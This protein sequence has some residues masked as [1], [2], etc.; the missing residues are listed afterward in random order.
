MIGKLKNGYFVDP[1]SG[2]AFKLNLIVMGDFGNN[3]DKI[4]AEVGRVGALCQHEAED[5]FPTLGFLQKTWEIAALN[6]AKTAEQIAS[7]TRCFIYL[8]K[9][10]ANPEETILPYGFEELGFVWNGSNNKVYT[11]HD[12]NALGYRFK[13]IQE[14]QIPES[15]TGETPTNGGTTTSV[16]FIHIQC[17]KCGYKIF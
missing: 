15:P 17:P 5:C 11:P 14:S 7:K 2:L 16:G 4:N 6:L 3:M 1:A 10:I 13:V 9:E 8:P 12:I